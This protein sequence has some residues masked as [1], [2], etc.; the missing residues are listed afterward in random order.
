MRIAPFL[1]GLLA[2]DFSFAAGALAQQPTGGGRGGAV[3][4]A[5]SDDLQKFCPD[6]KGRDRRQCL[7]ENK[8]KLSDG[9]KAAI[10]AMR[11][12]NEAPPEDGK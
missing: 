10:A 12:Q 6:A 4:Q 2:V 11:R 1:I 7:H 5:C 8:D 3:M 9:C